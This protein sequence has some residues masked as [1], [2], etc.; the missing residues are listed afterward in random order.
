MMVRQG[1]M[2]RVRFPAERMLVPGGPPGPPGI[3]CR[4]A[5]DVQWVVARGQVALRAV[6]GQLGL[7]L[8]ADLRGVAAARVEPA[9]RRR[10]DR[11]GDVAFEHDL[12]P[13]LRGLRV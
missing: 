13:L 9:S 12:P 7:D 1:R 4:L 10:R 8:R 5:A 3:N 2:S 6:C 11:A